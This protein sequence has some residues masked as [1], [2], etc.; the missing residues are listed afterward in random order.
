MTIAMLIAIDAAGIFAGACA[1]VTFVEHPARVACG[2]AAAIQEFGPSHRRATIMQAPLAV[3]GLVAGILSWIQGGGVGWLLGGAL[4][5]TT[6][7][8]TL[9]IV[10][11]ESG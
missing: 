2:A 5:G 8:F 6:V 1:Y 9:T 3:A 11:R 7:P 4:I 10:A